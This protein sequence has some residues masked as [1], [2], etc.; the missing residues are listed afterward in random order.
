MF[1]NIF[2]MG[3]L[4]TIVVGFVAL[5]VYVAITGAKK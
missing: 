1:V 2:W 5:I 4:S 3:V